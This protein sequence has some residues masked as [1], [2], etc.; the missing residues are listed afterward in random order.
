MFKH[1]S[2]LKKKYQLKMCLILATIINVQ[3]QMNTL[4]VQS[5][6]SGFRKYGFDYST[7]TNL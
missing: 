6:P 1:P 7:T 5:I 4:I 2:K 3:D